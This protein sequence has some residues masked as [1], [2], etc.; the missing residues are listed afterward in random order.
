MQGKARCFHHLQYGS[1]T[2]RTG[3]NALMITKH[4]A[5]K[6]MAK[7]NQRHNHAT[8]LGKD[9]ISAFNNTNKPEVMAIIGKH[10]PRLSSYVD[11]FLRQREFTIC[12]DSKPQG[13]VQ[14]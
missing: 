4:L 8:A 11:N 3:I 1:R 5:S 13:T 6:S 14:G 10:A 12:W 2:G 7:A 9:I